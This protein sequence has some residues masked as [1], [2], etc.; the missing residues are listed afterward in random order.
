[1]E[2]V[3]N[4]KDIKGILASVGIGVSTAAEWINAFEGMLKI[5]VSLG[6]LYAAYH[7]GQY[8]KE[9]RAAA[10]AAHQRE[11]LKRKLQDEPATTTL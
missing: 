1:M 8:W 7:A 11:A 10:R 2:S 6:G 5:A 9:K 3:K 4:M